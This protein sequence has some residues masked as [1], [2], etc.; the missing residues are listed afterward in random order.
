MFHLFIYVDAYNNSFKTKE[1]GLSL[2]DW[3]ISDVLIILG[4]YQAFKTLEQKAAITWAI[5]YELINFIVSRI[6]WEYTYF[7]G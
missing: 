4:T 1:K 6:Y 2:L 3:E 7:V 5:K